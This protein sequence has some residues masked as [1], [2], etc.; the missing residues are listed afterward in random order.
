MKKKTK[1]VALVSSST[2]ERK[3]ASRKNGFVGNF[4]EATV[5]LAWDFDR[6]RTGTTFHHEDW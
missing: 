5:N 6:G 4:G 1:M 2:A 3:A